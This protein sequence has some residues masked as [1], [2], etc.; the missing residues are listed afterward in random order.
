MKIYSIA[1]QDF[2]VSYIDAN[3]NNSLAFKLHKINITT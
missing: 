3:T 2:T 1:V